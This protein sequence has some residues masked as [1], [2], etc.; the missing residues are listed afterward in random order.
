MILGQLRSVGLLFFITFSFVPFIGVRLFGWDPVM[1]LVAYFLDRVVYL[2]FYAIMNRIMLSRAKV[3]EKGSVL[4]EIMVVSICSYMMIQF[5]AFIFSLGGT[6]ELQEQIYELGIIFICIVLFYGFMFF[7]GL[8]NT[9]PASWKD[10]VFV[11][12]VGIT[13]LSA[14]IGMISFSSA[15]FLRQFAEG[16]FAASFFGTGYGIMIFVFVILRLISDL[17][18]FAF[19]N[20]SIRSRKE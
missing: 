11:N 9:D 20:S 12:A 7:R 10:Q 5:G 15:I 16:S 2:I 19:A 17:I 14:F 3:Q 1:M 18:F 6:L 8:Q 13:L 4:R